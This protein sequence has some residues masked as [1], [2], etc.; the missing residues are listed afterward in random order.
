MVVA[1]VDELPPLN[2]EF[3]GQPF[4]HLPG[5]LVEDLLVRWPIFGE[6]V[7]CGVQVRVYLPDAGQ[8]GTGVE[9]RF[10]VVVFGPQLLFQYEILYGLV[11]I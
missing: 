9:L 4:A 3:C 7:P 11:V 5:E 6:A 1:V 10:H 2:Q 8:R